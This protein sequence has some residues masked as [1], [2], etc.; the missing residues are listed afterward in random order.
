MRNRF[1]LFPLRLRVPSYTSRIVY[2]Q[3]ND[4]RHKR[5]ENK[6]KRFDNSERVSAPSFQR[7]FDPSDMINNEEASRQKRN[8][9]KKKTLEEKKISFVNDWRCKYLTKWIP[10]IIVKTINQP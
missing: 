9:I 2:E 5:R 1:P 4:D 6:R 7:V 10:S 3:L 8:L